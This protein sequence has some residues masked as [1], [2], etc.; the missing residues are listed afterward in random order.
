MRIGLFVRWSSTLSALALLL[1]PLVPLATLRPVPLSPTVM[2]DYGKGVR[3]DLEALALK[4]VSNAEGRSRLLVLENGQPLPVPNVASGD[5][6]S[7]GQGRYSHWGPELTFAAS[8][9]TDPRTNGRT[10]SLEVPQNLLDYVRTH[11]PGW[12]KWEHIALPAGWISGLL[13]LA[14]PW[15]PLTNLP[16]SHRR[17]WWRQRT[18]PCLAVYGGLIGLAWLF[19]ANALDIAHPGP[20]LFFG[21][22]AASLLFVFL[23]WPYANWRG[24]NRFRFAARMGVLPRFAAG[25]V[26]TIL[27][28]ALLLFAVEAAARSFPVIDS[29]GNNPGYRYLWPAWFGPRNSLGFLDKEPGQKKG[30]RV[31]LLGDSFTEGAG[32]AVHRRYSTPLEERLQAVDP[33]MDVVN[34]GICSLDTLREAEILEQV[35]DK[36]RPDVVVVG[37]VLNDAECDVPGAA[38]PS[39]GQ[40]IVGKV[41]Q[42]ADT[43]F[44][45]TLHSYA[46][47]RVKAFRERWLCHSEDYVELA[48]R[49]HAPGSPGWQRVLNGLD[50]IAGWCDQ[51]GVQRNLVVFPYFMAGRDRGWDIAGQVVAAATARGFQARSTLDDYGDQLA[52]LGISAFD[53]HPNRFAHA[54]MAERLFE[55]LGPLKL[56]YHAPEGRLQ[57]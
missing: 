8:D 32:V 19:Y 56:A 34:A 37:Y 24:E 35:G 42:H 33:S 2:T 41:F 49:Q 4:V 10:Y 52:P 30:P 50:R 53:A 31:L 27:G 39:W 43:L 21:L 11:W 29:F 26:N 25:A 47:Y 17:H 55:F 14:L 57:R 38:P 44:L 36:V 20:R 28:I 1:W 54:R 18:V 16:V 13:L 40:Q 46:Y 15:A 9:N 5:V 7:L 3:V 45:Q 12:K 48:R 6:R 22:I 23:L 51:R